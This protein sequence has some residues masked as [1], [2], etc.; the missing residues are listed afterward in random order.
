[1]CPSTAELRRRNELEYPERPDDEATSEEAS[2]AVGHAEEIVASA[3]ALL[4]QLG[5]F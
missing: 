2:E 4:D 3:K 5:L 1:M